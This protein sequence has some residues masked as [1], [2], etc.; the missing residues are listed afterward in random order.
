[1]SD[2]TKIPDFEEIPHKADAEIIAY[3]SSLDELFIHALQGMYFIMGIEG[4]HGSESVDLV[5]LQDSNLESLLVS[6]LTEM[7]F[8][9]EKGFKAEIKHLEVKGNKLNARITKIPFTGITKEIKAVT[10]NEMRIIKKNNLFQ[11]RIVFDI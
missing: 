2:I 10:F 1:M 9:V 3:G 6:F 11:T 7:L 5:S 4:T 8:I